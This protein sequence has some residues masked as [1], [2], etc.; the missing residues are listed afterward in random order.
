MRLT[1]SIEE[2]AF[3]KDNLILNT[4]EVNSPISNSGPK[5]E[6]VMEATVTMG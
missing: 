3:N 2:I 4:H 1:I 6:A 5:T